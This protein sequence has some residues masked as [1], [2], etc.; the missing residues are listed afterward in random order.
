MKRTFVS[1]IGLV[2]LL[3]F[4]TTAGIQNLSTSP[5]DWESIS[6]SAMLHSRENIIV[7]TS[8]AD[9]GPGSLR[10]AFLDAQSGDTITFDTSIFPPDKPATIFLISGL[11]DL[12][13]GNLTVNA[14]NAGVIVDGSAA[15]DGE[16]IP[17]LTISSEGNSVHGLQIVNFSG[18][19]IMLNEQANHNI[20]GGDRDIGAGPI[21]YGNLISGNSDG[22]G[23]VG[24]SDNIIAGNLIGTDTTGT[25]A[26]GNRHPG[27]FVEGEA[28][29]NFIGP[30]N[31]IA[32]SDNF[33]I[34]VRS[35]SGF[36]N[37]ITQNN[38][39]HNTWSGIH[40]QD[41]S[42]SKITAPIV[43]DFDLVDGTVSGIA[44]L[45][46]S[47]EI[48]SDSDDEGEIYEGVTT[49]DQGGW[50]SI[51]NGDSF[52]GPHLTATATDSEGNTSEF[53]LPTY[54]THRSVLL[55]IGNKLPRRILKPKESRELK[56]NS[57]GG[58]LSPEAGS[59]VWGDA[60]EFLY[61]INDYGL[62]R[63]RLSIDYFDFDMVDWEAGTYSEYSIELNHENTI[64]GLIDYGIKIIYC[65]T[66]WDPDSPGQEPEEG[67]SRFRTAD[68][69][70]RYLDYAR[71]IVS[72]FKGRVDYYEIL[73]EPVTGS[74]TQQS[75]EVEDYINLVK[76]VVPVIHQ[77]D[78]KAKIVV[79]STP[80][81]Y[82]SGDFDYL[83]SI[84][85]SDLMPIVDG[86]S[87]HPMHGASPDYELREYYYSYPSVIQEIKDVATTNGFTGEYMAD[88]LVWRTSE[89]PLPSEPWIYTEIAAAKY[90]AR[91]ITQQRG[92]DLSTTTTELG[93]INEH[94]N[95]RPI[96]RVLQNLATQ[97]A[98]AE[99]ANLPIQIQ[100]T[101]TNTVSYTFSLSNGAL[102]IALY[103]DGAAVDN[104]PGT[105]ATVTIPGYE[106][107][108]VTGIDVLHGF[109]Q[110]MITSEEN[111]DLVI[112]DLLLKDY[113][114]ILRLAPAR[115]VYLPAIFWGSDR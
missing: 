73:N 67:Y 42:E 46:C 3:F 89:N 91:G 53:S 97:M 88:E 31:I 35:L 13:L 33:G 50:F 104:D 95:E 55:Q 84:L 90:Y 29:R 82:N 51:S 49:A 26:H 83:M 105:P 43:L 4:G 87:F 72:H 99:P 100:S 77:E 38:I 69:I 79:G 115:Y 78:P 70:Q 12:N 102:L 94:S 47:I 2:V 15:L 93:F 59:R 68:E 60:D 107:Y 58:M 16:W 56:D 74:G 20:I 11:P 54:S 52:T 62:K 5:A 81:L 114:I 92:L 28:N 45:D 21:G 65:L 80:N 112:R 66:F 27:I 108:E 32:F 1:M 9:N 36:S 41:R 7:V 19:G 6:D 61:Y 23:I 34:D 71:F 64:N 76:N 48:F 44:C 24:A 75:V 8:T 25:I 40:L 96:G 30:G 14:S 22:I 113:P 37:T 106:G 111:G 86:I 98:G 63:I 57:I 17:G 109:Q 101:V 110:Q 103:T 39:H 10:Q 85:T 18:A